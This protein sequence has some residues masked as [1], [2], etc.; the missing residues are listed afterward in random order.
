MLGSNKNAGPALAV[1]PRPSLLIVDSDADTRQ[2]YRE[3]FTAEGYVVDDCDDGAEAL[4][5][6]IC[7]PP[8]VI[9][10]DTHVRRIH[11]FALC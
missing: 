11:G 10:M 8:D 4:G 9:V 3:I 5:R 2:L 1:A 7:R 6:A